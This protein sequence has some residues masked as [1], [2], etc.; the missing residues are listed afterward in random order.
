MRLRAGLSRASPGSP[1]NDKPA[2][3]E[4]HLHPEGEA[5]TADELGGHGIFPMRVAVQLTG[6]T[7]DTIRAWERRYNAIEPVRSAGNTRKFTQDDIRR[8]LLLREATE[9]GHSIGNIAELDNE[10][11]RS[12]KRV[13]TVPSGETAPTVAP[14]PGRPLPSRVAEPVAL[15]GAQDTTTVA[16]AGEIDLGPYF[17]LLGR[18][19]LGRSSAWM[20]RV[21]AL[22]EPRAF[23]LDVVAP[24]LSE[25]R[26]RR[27]DA[28]LGGPHLIAAWQQL[29]AVLSVL[30]EATATTSLVPGVVTVGVTRQR[31]AIAAM[32]STLLAREHGHPASFLGPSMPDA[33]VMWAVDALEAKLVIADVSVPMSPDSSPNTWATFE[34]MAARTRVWLLTPT[35][36][37]APGRLDTMRDLAAVD[38]ALS[39]GPLERRS[40]P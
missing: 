12:L 5:S 20:R 37:T 14:P 32:A 10:A 9:A 28:R 21:A 15:Y 18:Y 13:A 7:S 26:E 35:E 8:L 17:E 23:V 4:L 3:D 11:L 39:Q 22:L 2:E 25:I 24:A 40:R 27:A 1:V 30:L 29:T 19:D 33:D 34:R 16:S 6:L 38:L 31:H 36:V